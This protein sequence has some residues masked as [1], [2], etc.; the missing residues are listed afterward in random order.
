MRSRTDNEDRQYVENQDSPERHSHS[1]WY[2]LPRI[3][4]LAAS[5]CYDL[6]V[7]IAI[8][9]RNQG[10]PKSQKA[11]SGPWHQVAIERAWI[12]PVSETQS[13][14]SRRATKVDDYAGNDENDD[15]KDLESGKEDFALSVR[16]DG[17]EVEGEDDDNED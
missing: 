7:R 2:N 16:F 3:L 1:L 6:D 14:L 4:R 5:K 8:R 9:S 12:L 15:E 13:V 10:G 17:R 11:A